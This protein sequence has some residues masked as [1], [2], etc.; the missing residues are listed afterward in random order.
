MTGDRR[1]DNK[2]CTECLKT[3]TFVRI[4]VGWQC[5]VCGKILRNWI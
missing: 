3:R 2:Y 1:R 5:T 4:D